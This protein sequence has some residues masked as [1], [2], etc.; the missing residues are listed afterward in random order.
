MLMKD[1]RDL[2]EKKHLIV[3]IC[4]THLMNAFLI[5]STPRQ[6][7]R[8]SPIENVP[9][10][11]WGELNEQHLSLTRS[12]IK[13][14]DR[15]D[16]IVNLGGRDRA[17]I[18]IKAGLRYECL[19]EMCQQD[20]HAN[21]PVVSLMSALCASYLAVVDYQSNTLFPFDVSSVKLSKQIFILWRFLFAHLF[22][23]HVL[24][25]GGGGAASANYL[26]MWH[27]VIS[28][29]AWEAFYP[30]AVWHRANRGWHR[31]A[32]L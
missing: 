23:W 6:P 30:T 27:I 4:F 10:T 1:W 8:Q 32:P 24:I 15:C 20:A 7:A 14:A 2:V 26:I 9:A 13:Y 12:V 31:H 22:A 5:V 16:N 29:R 17:S 18:P 3:T 19:L 21:E 25:R 11:E 28:Q